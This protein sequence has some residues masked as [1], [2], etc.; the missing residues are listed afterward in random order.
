M[1]LHRASLTM[2]VAALVMAAA[3]VTGF[4]AAGAGEAA[5]TAPA[6]VAMGMGEAPMLAALVAA[7]EL[8]PVEE[9]LPE[10]PFVREV[11]GEIGQYGGTIRASTGRIGGAV[12]QVGWIPTFDH[13]LGG[14]FYDLPADPNEYVERGMHLGAP[15][16]LYFDDYTHNPDYTEMTIRFRKGMKWS[17][18]QPLTANDLMWT[19]ENIWI[20]P[21]INPNRPFYT[22]K[23]DTKLHL[24]DD[25]TIRLTSSTPAPLQ[26]LLLLRDAFYAQHWMSQFHPDENASATWDGLREHMDFNQ[27]PEQPQLT[28]WVVDEINELEQTILGTRN[29][30]YPVVDPAGN[31]LPYADHLLYRVVADEQTALLLAVQGELDVQQFNLRDIEAL[32]EGEERGNYTVTLWTGAA[33]QGWF[34]IEHRV[35]DDKLRRL[36]W[37]TDFRR[38]LSI[39]INREEMN[40]TLWFGAAE[41][42]SVPI[43]AESIYYQPEMDKWAAYDPQRAREMLDGLG[44]KDTDGDGFREYPDGS[45]LE[46]VF[47]VGNDSFIAIYVPQAEMLVKYWE[48]VGLDMILKATGLSNLYAKVSEGEVGMMMHFGP[49]AFF[50]HYPS[51]GGYGWWGPER[52]KEGLRQIDYPDMPAVF[53]AAYDRGK[54]IDQELDPEMH[55]ELVIDYWIWAADVFPGKYGTIAKSVPFPVVVSNRMGNVPEDRALAGHLKMDQFYIKQ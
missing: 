3:S 35:A 9:R 28:A 44:L 26:P 13:E 39:A 22:V 19:Y 1:K 36:L 48:D 50:T 49:R 29:A 32:K 27:H 42:G 6:T 52:G 24:V 4:A 2:V 18:G 34:G 25:L 47:W 45:K 40:D 16:L 54:R 51:G 17:D 15:R 37:E 12:A 38:A 23:G 10:D 21:Q 14:M 53:Q 33:R 55:K 31:Q 7:G 46:I 20:H 11:Y 43:V 41:M 5:T 8:P 30:Y